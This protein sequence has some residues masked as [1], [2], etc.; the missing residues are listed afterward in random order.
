MKTRESGMPPEEMWDGFF[1]PGTT[2]RKLGLT[3]DCRCAVDFGCGYGTFAIPAAKLIAGNLYALDIDAEMIAVTK[4][5]AARLTNLQVCQRDFVEAGS[6]LADGAADYAMLFNILHAT[7]AP[8]LLAEAKR[9]LKIGGTLA[10]MH[11]NYDPSTP[12]GPSMDIRL[13]PAQ[14]VDLVREARFSVG[15]LVDLLPYHY[16][17]VATRE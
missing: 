11:W 16:G 10:V 4:S 5:K 14:C 1:D 6:G 7:E 9:V 17:F 13:K 8:L 2:L 12:R 15:E 3:P